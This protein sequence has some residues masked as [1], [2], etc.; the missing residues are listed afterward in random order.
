MRR[1]RP[2]KKAYSYSR[3]STPEQAQGDSATRQAL[4]AHR[5]AEQ[6][7]VELDTDLRFRDEGVSA[8]R[9][10]QR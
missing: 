7:G 8:F 4:A 3:F 2:A 10:A 9:R 6:H 1:P 5:W